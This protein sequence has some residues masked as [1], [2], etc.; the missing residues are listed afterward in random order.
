MEL[1]L[2]GMA[3][4]LG[5]SFVFKEPMATEAHVRHGIFTDN[6]CAFRG[7]RGFRGYLP[8]FRLESVISNPDRTLPDPD[9]THA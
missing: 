1:T 2:I 8:R 6:F 3:L 9:Q 4:S 7:F 5:I